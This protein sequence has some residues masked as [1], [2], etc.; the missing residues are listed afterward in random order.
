[1]LGSALA[2]SAAGGAFL[3][4]MTQKLTGSF[5]PFLLLTAALTVGGS[6]L[7]LLLGR[8]SANLSTD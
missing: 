2:V 4:S 3:L 8:L 1:M 7:F 6:V 5:T